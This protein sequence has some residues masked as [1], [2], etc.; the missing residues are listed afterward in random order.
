MIRRSSLAFLWG[1]ISGLFDVRWL[2]GMRPAYVDRAAPKGA[3][4]T[5]LIPAHNEEVHLRAAVES[6]FEQ[7][8]KLY[9]IIIIDDGS[10][11]ATGDIAEALAKENRGLVYVVHTGG[12]GSKSGALNAG[13]DSGFPLGEL[14]IVMDAD[15]QF[16]PDAIEKALPY[17]YDPTVAVVCGHVLPKPPQ[18]GRPSLW[19]RSKLVEYILGQGLTK[20]AQNSLGILLVSSGCFSMYVTAYIG[21]FSDETMAEDMQKTW[22]LQIQGWKAV[23]A[24]ES[25]CYAAEP[26][27]LKVFWNQRWR[28]LCGFLQC[29]QLLVRALFRYNVRLAVVVHYMFV[30]ALMDV[31]LVPVALYIITKNA[32]LAV[33]LPSVMDV[34]VMSLAL[35]CYAYHIGGIG[36]VWKSLCSVPAA[37]WGS[38]VIRYSFLSAIVSEW[39]L[40]RRLKKWVA[41]H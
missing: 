39:F 31:V 3:T 41:G 12:T 4:V 22:E 37:L 28:W 35:C 36:L 20:A 2:L 6:L 26:E 10:K 32:L 19:W 16:D 11:D 33:L 7:T 25:R 34:G 29:Y 24:P 23:Y 30:A 9:S 40:R 5:I 27:S 1:G 8:Y 21:R 17:F 38:A 14:S 18:G 15:T 13:L